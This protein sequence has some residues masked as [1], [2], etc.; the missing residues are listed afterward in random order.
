MNIAYILDDIDA[1][2]GIQAVTRAKAVALAAIPG[3]EVTLVAANDA[4]PGGAPLP[5]G[6][7]AVHLG[8]NYYED[9]WKGFLY[10]L[11]GIF[12]RRRKHAARLRQALAQLQPDVVISVGQAEKFM[13]PRL[14]RRQ[15][16]K[17]VREFHYARTYRRDYARLQ[18]GLRARIVAWLSDAYENVLR[19]GGYDATVVLTREDREANWPGR[20]DVTVIPNPCVR[21]FVEPAPLDTARAIAVGRLVPVKG[22]DLLIRAWARVAA[23][24]PNWQLDI[25]GEGPERARLQGLIDSQG[26]GHAV[27][28]R[29]ATPEIEREMA[30]ASMLVFPSLFEGFGM[31]LVEAMACGVPCVAFGCPCGPRDIITH[32]QDGLLVLPRNIP[33]LADALLSLIDDPAERRRLGANAREKARAFS[34]EAVAGQWMELFC[35][36]TQSTDSTHS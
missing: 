19:R 34:L 8:V 28:L 11:K 3:N 15:P 12:V 29:G 25:W 30:A 6:V 21:S 33:A 2:G 7:R 27:A 14:A 26:L 10:V 18:G 32:G 24:R 31:V 5:P 23:E 13:I 16:Y 4:Q 9:D 36:L 22:F 1:A 35:S 17:T 20:A